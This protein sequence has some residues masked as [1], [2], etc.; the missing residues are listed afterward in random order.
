MCLGWLKVIFDEGLYDKD[1]VDRWCAGFEALK[2]E[3]TNTRLTVP[4][5]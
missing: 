1:F 3:L 4:S 5:K 2:L